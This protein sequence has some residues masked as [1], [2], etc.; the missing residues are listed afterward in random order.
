MDEKAIREIA[1][2]F[3][4]CLLDE[5]KA[6]QL[7]SKAVDVYVDLREK[8]VLAPSDQLVVKATNEVFLNHVTSIH[9]GSPR[10]S[11]KFGF[12][13]PDQLNFGPWI[14]FQ[15]QVHLEDLTVFVWSLILGYKDQD[16]ADALDLSPGTIRYRNDHSLKTMGENIG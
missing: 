12:H 2:F 8:N 15:K 10:I 1:L 11:K 7:A 6:Y 3:F 4:F 16:V 14:E 9:R 5:E 13:W